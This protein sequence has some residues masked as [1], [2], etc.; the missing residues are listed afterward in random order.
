MAEV[1]V[2]AAANPGWPFPAE[3]QL[4]SRPVRSSKP[5]KVK[6]GEPFDAAELT[7]KLEKHRKEQEVA[8]IRRQKREAI[9]AGQPQAYIP[10]NA[11]NDFH[12]TATPEPFGKDKVHALSQCVLDSYTR[13]IA[14]AAHSGG[15]NPKQLLAARQLA[16]AQSELN[17][18]R[19]QFQQSH[20]LEKVAKRG[21]DR[22]TAGNEGDLSDV[23]PSRRVPAVHLD[24]ARSPAQRPLSIAFEC[25]SFERNSVDEHLTR[26]ALRPGDRHNWAQE[27]EC[28]DSVHN[29][30]PPNV[31]KK[32]EKPQEAKPTASG[33]ARGQ[34]ARSHDDQS[35]NMIA[36]AVRLLKVKER[37]AS[38]PTVPA[39]D[40]PR[41][42]SSIMRIFTRS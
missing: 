13:G 15:Y 5:R 32:R 37:K 26:P 39:E 8:R 28:G 1:D 40:R 9:A 11:A 34:R 16:L 36:D 6:Q 42:R 33:K 20:D 19:N 14:S 29:L 23:H 12:N 30:P 25:F 38:L 10:K 21:R 4:D 24:H 18:E 3:N 31:L 22:N 2:A 7:R 17:A 41:R 27:S 35:D